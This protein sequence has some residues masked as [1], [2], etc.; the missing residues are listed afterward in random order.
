MGGVVTAADERGE[1]STTVVK[2]EPSCI[3]QRCLESSRI[4]GGGH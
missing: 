1:G 4:C 3:M 2:E